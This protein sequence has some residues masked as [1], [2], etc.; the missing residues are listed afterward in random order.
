LCTLFSGNHG[1]RGAIRMSGAG[2]IRRGGDH[3]LLEPPM[4]WLEMP[5]FLEWPEDR[6]DR[7]PIKQPSRVLG[8]LRS[9][10]LRRG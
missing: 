8:G 6:K 5:V 2:T 3:E 10:L 1:D 9:L 7:T 4:W